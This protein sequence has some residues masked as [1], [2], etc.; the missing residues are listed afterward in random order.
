[1][2]SLRTLRL[3]RLPYSLLRV[4]SS[5]RL[6]IEAHPIIPTRMIQFRTILPWAHV[7]NLF[8]GAHVNHL[9]FGM[10]IGMG[11]NMSSFPEDLSVPRIHQSLCGKLFFRCSTR[12]GVEPWLAIH[13]IHTVKLTVGSS[14]TYF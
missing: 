12:W 9:I 3:L 6:A 2:A 4:G 5:L 11:F 8:C 13:R 14:D 1:M 10:T 7:S